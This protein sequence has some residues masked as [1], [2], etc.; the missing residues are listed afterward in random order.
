MQ[1]QIAM[2]GKDENSFL[3]KLPK[4][5]LLDDTDEENSEAN[6]SG[7][8]EEEKKQAR[9]PDADAEAESAGEGG[10]INIEI[11]QTKPDEDRKEAAKADDEEN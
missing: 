2:L 8:E 3:G 4:L 6:A 11:G 5:D 10:A 7:S 1:R 9:E